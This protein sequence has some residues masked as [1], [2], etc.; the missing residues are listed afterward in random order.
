M[1]YRKILVVF[2]LVFLSGGVYAAP[3][4][5]PPPIY[6]GLD[7]EFGYT[8]STSAEAIRQGILLALEEINQQ[9]VLGGRKLVL[10]EKANHSVPSRSLNNIRSFAKIPDVVA[11]YCGRFSPTVLEALPLIHALG[12]PLLDPWAA[13]DA[14]IDHDFQPNYTFRLSLRDSWAIPAL[15]REAEQRQH[16]RL[17]LLLLNTSWGRSSLAA[18][19]RYVAARPQMQLV[20]THWFNWSDTSFRE[21]YAALRSAGAEALVLVANANE[22]AILLHEMAQLPKEARLP[23][24]S[25]WGIVGGDL[26]GM[27]G[28]AL[29]AVELYVPQTF[30]F[31]ENTKARAMQV[32]QAAQRL[33]QLAEPQ[34][35]PAQVGLAHAYDLTHILALAIARAG[36]TERGAIRQALEQVGPY[37]GLIRYYE[38]PFQPT[39]HEA[40]TEREVFVARYVKANALMPVR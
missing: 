24:Y 12:L 32:L 11:V 7:G 3:G 9:G 35:L 6:I 39:R 30:T 15:L 33:F 23:L 22:A 28:P 20:A 25:H 1:L 2:W 40:L 16:T 27:A 17:G 13:A 29:Q 34:Y 18:A 14:I 21:K 36:S 8:G 37:Q 19:E 38:Q 10:L 26:A 4:Q 31:V 5:E